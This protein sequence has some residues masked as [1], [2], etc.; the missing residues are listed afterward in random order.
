MGPLVESGQPVGAL[1]LTTQ[2]EVAQPGEVP[3]PAEPSRRPECL[4]GQ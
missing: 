3:S 1:S 4:L 2:T